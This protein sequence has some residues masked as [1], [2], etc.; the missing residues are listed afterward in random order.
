VVDLSPPPAWFA[1]R[2]SGA[3]LHHCTL[4]DE[5]LSTLGNVDNLQ[6]QQ[7]GAETIHVSLTRKPTA[8][9]DAAF[10]ASVVMWF[11]AAN[12]RTLDPACHGAVWS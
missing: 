12:D 10:T 8:V 3:V 9:Q 5:R 11:S 6:I 4:I 7:T 2:A 1:A